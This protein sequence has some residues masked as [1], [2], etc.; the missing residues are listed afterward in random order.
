MSEN[1][2]QKEENQAGNQK[3]LIGLARA[4]GGAILFSFSILMTMEMWRLGFYI[5]RFRLALFIIAFMPM[6]FGLAYF[7]GFEDT[8][9]LTEDAVDAFVAY[10]VGFIASALILFAF[11]IINFQMPFD[12]ILGKISIQ[13][14]TAA[15][16]ALVAQSQLGGKNGDSDESKDNGDSTSQDNN[17]KSPRSYFGEILLMIIGVIFLTMSIAPTEE[18]ILIAFRMTYW[19]SFALAIGTLL[20]MHTVV[21][22]VK[23]RGQEKSP[24]GVSF[25]SIFARY[26]IVGYA[27]V[28]LVCL[29][30]LWTFGRTSGMSAEE[31]TKVTIVLGFP[32][33]LGAAGSR[34]I[35]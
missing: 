32:G 17:K 25:L 1:D 31:I 7:D 14:I 21:Y 9:S 23:F 10:A 30:L 26:T 19:H 2:S 5:D 27:V 8:N 35:L 3:F 33:A 4:F 18:M 13:A 28:L 15:V 22:V 16:G 12:E 24:K 29:Y 34:L 6:L 11:N 20:M